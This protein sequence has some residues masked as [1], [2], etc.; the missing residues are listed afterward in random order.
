MFKFTTILFA[1]LAFTAFAQQ[2]LADEAGSRTEKTR[3]VVASFGAAL[4][5]GDMETLLGLFPGDAEWRVEGHPEVPWVG[6]FVGPGRIGDLLGVLAAEI[7]VIGMAPTAAAFD[8]ANA[9]LAN[10]M[11]LRMRGSG[12]TVEL[13]VVTHLEVIDGQFTKYHVYEDTLALAEAYLSD[14]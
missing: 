4:G 9:F 11:T 14:R 7:E 2:T 10:T 6:S 8:G 3:Q 13:N 12:E 1:T 5:S